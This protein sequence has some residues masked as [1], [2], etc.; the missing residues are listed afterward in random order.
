MATRCMLDNLELEI[1]WEQEIVF[2]L[3]PPSMALESTQ[4]PVQWVQVLLPGSY[5]TGA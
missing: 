5:V 3:H 2:S 4:P 1:R